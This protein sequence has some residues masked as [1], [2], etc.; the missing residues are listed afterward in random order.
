[1]EFTL[2]GGRGCG[3][4]ARHSRRSAQSW[5]P[6]EEITSPEESESTTKLEL[7]EGGEVYTVTFPHESK[8]GMLLEKFDE[9]YDRS[10]S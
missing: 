8:L 10:S 9:V 5:S 4:R 7:Q 2:R 1:L 3:R 6:G